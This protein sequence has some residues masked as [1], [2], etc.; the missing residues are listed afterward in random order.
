MKEG[1]NT[2]PQFFDKGQQIVFISERDG[3]KQIYVMN[4]DGSSERALTKASVKALHPTVAPDENKVFFTSEE[5]GKPL[6][7]A[8]VGIDGSGFHRLELETNLTP[9]GNI[10][11][12][13]M[14][15]AF[16][17][18]GK[19]IYLAR[20]LKG[21]SGEFVANVF[22]LDFET[23]EAQQ[24]T[25][26][27]ESISYKLKSGFTHITPQIGGLSVSPNG[28]KLVCVFN[29]F[30]QDKPLGTPE[31]DRSEL[32]LANTDG[33][34]EKLLV[35]VKGGVVGI[36]FSPDGHWIAYVDKGKG[37]LILI[38]SEGKEKHTFLTDA[39]LTGYIDWIE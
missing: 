27:R 26:N 7:L 25:K 24:V 29:Y 1:N 31:L 11:E 12:C 37:A 14:H 18:D 2:C 17:P 32:K 35:N 21:S 22:S 28:T 16:S 30:K 39:R 20:M 5:K 3:K 15:N 9:G 33:S 34:E 10:F 36:D 13:V 4:A 38:D 8:E 19:K 6:C 23:K